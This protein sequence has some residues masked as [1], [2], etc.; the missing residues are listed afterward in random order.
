[1][2][3]HSLLSKVIAGS[4]SEDESGI[5]FISSLTDR[6]FQQVNQLFVC[7]WSM[8]SITFC[9][10]FSFLILPQANHSSFQVYETVGF[11]Q[12]KTPA[13]SRKRFFQ[14]SSYHSWLDYISS[15]LLSYSAAQSVSCKVSVLAPQLVWAGGNKINLNF[16]MNFS[17]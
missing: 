10:I 7:N 12:L 1:M 14:V 5:V 6:R 17:F 11:V 3:L 2:S 4:V 15:M 13:P 9:A 16:L 8:N